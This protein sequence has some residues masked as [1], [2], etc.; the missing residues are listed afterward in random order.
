MEC[1]RSAGGAEPFYLERGFEDNAKPYGIP[2]SKKMELAL[3][4]MAQA[5]QLES[6]QPNRVSSQQY[7][8]TVSILSK[9]CQN[10]IKDPANPKFQK[11][12]LASKA[13]QRHI[14]EVPGAEEF[15]QAIG[16]MRVSADTHLALDGER[17]REP[18]REAKDKNDRHGDV[19]YDVRG[20]CERALSILSRSPSYLDRVQPKGTQAAVAPSDKS[21]S[22]SL[23]DAKRQIPTASDHHTSLPRTKVPHPGLINSGATCYLN[24]LLQVYFHQPEFRK[25]I[26]RAPFIKDSIIHGLQD[27]FYSL[28]IATKPIS[29]RHLTARCFGWTEGHEQYMQHDAHELNR[30]LI[31]RLFEELKKSPALEREGK[32][33]LRGGMEAFIRCLDVDFSALKEYTKEEVL[34]ELWKRPNANLGPQKAAKGCRFRYFP[35]LLFLHLARFAYNPETNSRKKINNSFKFPPNINLAAFM[36]DTADDNSSNE[37]EEAKSENMKEESGSYQPHEYELVRQSFII[38]PRPK[39]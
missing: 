26:Y 37:G 2:P 30:I 33:L 9:I 32:T 12:K 14:V 6:G 22:N 7:L 13:V 38:H 29:T 20:L 10:I 31:D 18:T 21:S 11:L 25:L 19:D 5:V 36:P 8:K 23:H 24:A 15:L 35:P 1:F 27:L 28:T 4:R 3:R 17:S 39:K 34:S 16:F